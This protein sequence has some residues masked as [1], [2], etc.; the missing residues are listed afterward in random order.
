MTP[1]T[2]RQ[3]VVAGAEEQLQ[4][5]EV[6]LVVA[7]LR[8]AAVRELTETELVHVLEL[9]ES[10]GR[11]AVAAYLARLATRSPAAYAKVLRGGLA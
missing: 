7:T 5:H 4:P 6:D 9:D 11:V 10:R 1:P 8:E 2:L 3:L